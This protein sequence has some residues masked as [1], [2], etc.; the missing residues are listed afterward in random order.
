MVLT[1]ER[2]LDDSTDFHV[3]LQLAS[4][5]IAMHSL[6]TNAPPEVSERV[7]ETL[8][9]ALDEIAAVLAD[10]VAA[11]TSARAAQTSSFGCGT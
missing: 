1:R 7:G 8:V 9:K 6:L 4:R 2:Y 5:T 10:R 11:A 3:T